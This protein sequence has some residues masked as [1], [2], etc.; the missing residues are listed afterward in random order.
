MHQ[1]EPDTL[2]LVVQ[3]QQRQIEQLSG[4]L[5]ALGTSVSML[6]ALVDRLR[7]RMI[8]YE[9]GEALNQMEERRTVN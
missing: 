8:L 7:A 6:L 5:Q 2:V 1:V 9:A 4:A 3:E